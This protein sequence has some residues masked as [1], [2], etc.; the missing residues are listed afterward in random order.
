M[1]RFGIGRVWRGSGAL[2]VLLALAVR[3]ASPQGWMLAPGDG[4]GA[5][6]LVI[7]TGHMP[8]DW[9]A[10]AQQPGHSPKHGGTTDC[11]H[12]C[13]FAGMHA[14][15][16]PALLAASVAPTALA[17]DTQPTSPL[18]DQRPGRGLAAPPPPSQGPPDLA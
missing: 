12:P 9:I 7:C 15:P 18:T 17:L 14:P 3:L 1:G 4:S 6:R 13:A 10:A 2:L 8:A 16:A 11:D 5:P